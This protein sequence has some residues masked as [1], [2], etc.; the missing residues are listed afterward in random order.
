MKQS[1][2]FAIFFACVLV[3]LLCVSCGDTP[4]ETT[5][6]SKIE[7]TQAAVTT[8]EAQT[9]GATTVAAHEHTFAEAPDHPQAKA[10]TC[11]SVGVKVE[12]CTFEGCTEVKLSKIDKIPHTP[13]GEATCEAASICTVC[14]SEIVP[15]LAHVWG[16]PV[17][18]SG[19]CTEKGYDTYT[20]TLCSKA[21]KT[22]N[23]GIEHDL[24]SVVDT[25]GKYIHEK[26]KKCSFDEKRVNYET[27][28]SY[29]FETD[30]DIKT[31]L[32]E[33]QPGFSINNLATAEIKV[34]EAT[35]NKY[36]FFNG[37]NIID[38]EECLTLKKNR[39][40]MEFD[41]MFDKW[42]STAGKSTFTLM[43][44]LKDPEKKAFIWMMKVNGEH[45]EGGVKQIQKGE[46]VTIQNCSMVRFN[47]GYVFDLNKWY[48]ITLILDWAS[49]SAVLYA[50][51]ADQTLN[52]MIGNAY[53]GLQS[54][55]NPDGT[56]TG[57]PKGDALESTSMGFRFCDGGGQAYFDN[58]TAYASTIPAWDLSGLEGAVWAE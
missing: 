48:H 28:V 45:E 2:I 53:L 33:S 44:S 17:H 35:G 26:C 51:T 31:Y 10:P 7:T 47:T 58:F 40:V 16:Q 6:A 25:T 30:Q 27:L 32:N 38:D 21:T 14:N 52:E 19:S 57:I 8:Q 42:A 24:V 3:L 49:G 15:K 5:K 12:A 37:Q 1:K 23:T 18:T 50:R 41:I 56:M 43:P 11:S 36:A 46:W 22:V 55:E 39:V 29:D 13:N 20:C 4:A 9:T 54:T 34:D